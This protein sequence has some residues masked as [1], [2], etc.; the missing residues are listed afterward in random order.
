MPNT[1]KSGSKLIA[2]AFYVS[3]KLMHREFVGFGVTGKKFP[4]Y[5]VYWA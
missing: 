2:L 3:R 4:L 1:F 5:H